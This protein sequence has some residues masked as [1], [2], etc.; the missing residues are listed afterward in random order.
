[1]LA[2]EK[3]FLHANTADQVAHLREKELNFYSTN[4]AAVETMATLLAG[5]A[6]T[7][8][9]S[10]NDPL[11]KDTI[12]FLTREGELHGSLVDGKVTL[13]QS[14][15]LFDGVDF[16]VFAVAWLEVVSLVMCLAEMLYVLQLCLLSQLLGYRLA[17]RGPSGSITRSVQNLAESLSKQVQHSIA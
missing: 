5:F 14:T 11:S 8:F 3:E 1:M 9:V 13:Q 7:A 17:L 15:T 2:A 6:F 10:L 12:R 4:I 16:F